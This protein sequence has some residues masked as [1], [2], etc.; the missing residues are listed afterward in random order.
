V[1]AHNLRNI[2]LDLPRDRLIVFTGLSGSGKFP[3][4]FTTILCRGTEGYVESLSAY[5]RQFL[6]MMEKPDVDHHRR[7]VAG[8]R[9]SNRNRLRTNPAF[10]RCHGHGDFDYLRLLYARRERALPGPSHRSRRTNRQPMVDSGVAQ[11]KGHGVVLLAPIGAGNARAN[12][13]RVFE[14]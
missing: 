7:S 14:N 6:S 3:L 4:A 11:G 5:A 1:H 12:M 2:D 10:H 13:N 9:Q 8:H